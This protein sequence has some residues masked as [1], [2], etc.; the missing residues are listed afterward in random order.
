MDSQSE[1]GSK[2][3]KKRRKKKASPQG[4]NTPGGI[5]HEPSSDLPTS[6]ADLLPVPIT[7]TG[8]A[9]TNSAVTH[10]TV[11]ESIGS[12]GAC[13]TASSLYTAVATSDSPSSSSKRKKRKKKK[14]GQSAA[15]RGDSV[16]VSTESDSVPALR[17]AQTGSG[18][19][20]SS[21]LSAAQGSG[22]SSLEQELEWCIAQLEMGLSR[23]D[24]LKTQKQENLK[25]IRTLR[26]EKTALPRKRQLM[27][28]IFGDYRTR[29]RREPL[30][31]HCR[32]HF[33]ATPKISSV[34][35]KVS[36]AT[37]KYFKKSSQLHKVSERGESGEDSE[38]GLKGASVLKGISECAE[39]P[40]T[41]C[42]NFN[43]EP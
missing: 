15:V 36:E 4:R 38:W 19:G 17:D 13:G 43:V 27:K 3:S 9:A 34:E 5:E 6:P 7:A 8:P 18:G 40:K 24:A 16:L 11:A 41:F 30:P 12:A 37:G 42:F 2:A 20:A 39:Q 14:D 32:P 1:G 35:N 29:M 33:T 28:N 25:F 10:T 23:S 26:S 21:S 22:A 31:K